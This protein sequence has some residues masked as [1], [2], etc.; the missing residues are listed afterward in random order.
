MTPNNNGKI[1]FATHK[2]KNNQSRQIISTELPQN[3]EFPL[4]I[5]LLKFQNPL[6]PP[7]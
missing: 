3:I 5:P 4:F 6:P 7:H 1:I 2:E